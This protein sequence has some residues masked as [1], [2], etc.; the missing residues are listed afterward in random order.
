[1]FALIYIFIFISFVYNKECT[2][3]DCGPFN[4]AGGNPAQY[5]CTPSNDDSCIWKLLCNYVK[6]ANSGSDSTSFK[7]S[8]QPVSD[9][10]IYTCKDYYSYCRE[11]SF[12]EETNIIEDEYTNF[13]CSKYPLKD[14]TNKE[15]MICTRDVDNNKCIKQYLCGKNPELKEDEYLD[16]NIY[17][18]S[19]DKKYTYTCAYDE[20]ENK[21]YEKKL[22]CGEIYK[23][24]DNTVINCQE[25]TNDEILCISNYLE[26]SNACIQKKRCAKV[27]EED[28]MNQAEC[29]EFPVS[30]PELFSCVKNEE[31]KIC[32]EIYYCLQA[33]KDEEK[34]CS[35]FIISSENTE[36]HGCIEDPESDTYKCKEEIYCEQV[37]NNNN[38]DE[39]IN[40][41]NYPVKNKKTHVCIKNKNAGKDTPICKEE[42]LCQ[43]YT[44]G[45]SDEECRNY[46]VSNENTACIKN[47]NKNIGCIEKELCTTVPKGDNVD[48]SKYPVSKQNMNTHVCKNIINPSSS[49]HA[50][51]EVSNTQIECLKAEK[52]D[53]N[54][55]CS[56]YKVSD[57]SKKCVKNPSPIMHSGYTVCIE[58]TV[59]E[60]QLKTSGIINEEECNGLSV[61]NNNEQK[62]VKNPDGD[63]CMLLSYCEYAY[64][65]SDEDCAKYALKDEENE[66]CIK[67]KYADKCIVIEKEIEEIL[68]TTTEIIINTDKKIDINENN[69]NEKSGKR[70]NKANFINNTLYIIFIIYLFI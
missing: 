11:I 9:P 1:M 2:I 57:I 52:G 51:E 22:S 68:D 23:P 20:N 36:T 63:N 21:C 26:T 14:E 27:T 24:S 66:I 50:C 40:C 49:S 25:Y 44:Q 5:K 59:S 60:C 48:C 30:N 16:C 37:V 28:L 54:E 42:K 46:Y 34:D 55:Q 3:E 12:C 45:T 62:C 47:P 7:C 58:I 43:Y 33:P 67:S 35:E 15:N 4:I 38:N 19:Q 41:G 61:E 6:K 39:N 32:E 29:F 64:G 18:V 69:N 31:K 56:K 53:S 8:D 70:G 65:N 17:P 10:N 13:D